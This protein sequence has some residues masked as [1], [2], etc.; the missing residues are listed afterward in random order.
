MNESAES[1]SLNEV[2]LDLEILKQKIERPPKDF[3]DKLGAVS[4]LVGGVLVALVG[5]F[6]TQVYNVRQQASEA[7]R[8]ERELAVIQVQTVER[9]FDH[10][11]SNDE[12]IKEAA[13]DAI[14]A[15][16]NEELT[17]K[18]A[19]AFGGPGSSA[20][21]TKIASRSDSEAA[22][23]AE[24]A[25][26]EL[27]SAIRPS[28]VRIESQGKLVASGFFVTRSGLV[29]TTAHV[30]SLL[31]PGH[32]G[33]KMADGVTIPATVQKIDSERDLALL[34]AQTIES[35][36]PLK[37]GFASAPSLGTQVI[38]LGHSQQAQWMAVVGTVSANDVV[39]P[40]FR[41]PKIAV[42][43]QVYAGFSGAPVVSSQGSLI[44]IVQASRTGGNLT[45]LIPA[46]T[47]SSAFRQELSVGS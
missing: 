40:G 37:L 25:L 45:Y 30:A 44:G 33:I 46:D 47:I 23:S 2:K 24:A 9:F 26:S 39:V 4:T 19:L 38:A 8:R 35:V 11:T 16:G 29:L 18:L 21:L 41:G 17:T 5:G 36:L 42:D 31:K 3:W 15:L 22:K 12:R 1:S 7:A 14:A 6:A 34:K 28:V 10:L 32:I 20:A 13:L 43:M 27:F